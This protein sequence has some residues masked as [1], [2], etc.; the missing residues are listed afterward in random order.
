MKKALSYFMY[1]IPV[2]L[3]GMFALA[4]LEID[5][6]I[7]R[8]GDPAEQAAKR[9]TEI[10][11][12]MEELNQAKA[13]DFLLLPHGNDHHVYV[14]VTQHTKEHLVLR[15]CLRCNE[16]T[17]SVRELAEDRACLISHTMKE[18][19]EAARNTWFYQD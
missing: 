11:E 8:S 17:V 13:R 18:A 7:G 1:V 5:G 3:M 4:L 10:R 9:E 12:R 19:W 16:S 14:V 6:Q 2:C 15:L